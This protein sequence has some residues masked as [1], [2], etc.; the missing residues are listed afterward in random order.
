MGTGDDEGRCYGKRGWVPVS[1]R[2]REG[3][4]VAEPALRGRWVAR[5]D[6]TG[7]GEGRP[8]G[9]KGNGGPGEVSCREGGTGAGLKPAPTG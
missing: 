1:A 2:T 4:A 6:V 7:D 8:Y 5:L 3:G 9:G